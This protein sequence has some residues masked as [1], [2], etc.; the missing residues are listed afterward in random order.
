MEIDKNALY[1]S[2]SAMQ[3]AVRRSDLRLAKIA[4]R[5]VW[6]ADPWR[7]FARLHT[8]RAVQA[9][10]GRQGLPSGRPGGMS[11]MEVI[12]PLMLLTARRQP[13]C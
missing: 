3:K 1:L 9:F 8:V 10:L 7:C 2:L 4:G 6:E 12:S 11:H 5:V 13:T